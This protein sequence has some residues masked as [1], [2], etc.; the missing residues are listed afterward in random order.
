MLPSIHAEEKACNFQYFGGTVQYLS[1]VR[2]SSKRTMRRFVWGKASH[3]FGIKLACA[4]K[5][6]SWT[7]SDISR[8]YLAVDL[9]SRGVSQITGRSVGHRAESPLLYLAQE[10]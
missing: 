9:S 4:I 5:R 1:S 10:Q 3:N 8:R 6:S 2:R 7:M